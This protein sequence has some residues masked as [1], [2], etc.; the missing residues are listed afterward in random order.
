MLFSS[1]FVQKDGF[2]VFSD[3][4]VV[5]KEIQRTFCIQIHLNASFEVL[6]DFWK[7]GLFDRLL[8]EGCGDVQECGAFER[9]ALLEASLRMSSIPQGS[10][11]MGA[12]QGDTD[13]FE[14]E[15]PR[16]QVTLTRGFDHVSLCSVLF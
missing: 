16:H 10:F 1:L 9:E 13:A 15:R 4:C 14:D 7:D 11:F 6:D 3:D 12:L 2:L 8:F 5:S